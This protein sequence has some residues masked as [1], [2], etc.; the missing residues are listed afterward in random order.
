MCAIVCVFIFPGTR[1][2]VGWS[3]GWQWGGGFAERH[4]GW[5]LVA[6]WRPFARCLHLLGEK[7][8][9][10]PKLLDI[11]LRTSAASWDLGT[12]SKINDEERDAVL[13]F[14]NLKPARDCEI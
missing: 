5:K 3:C 11:R 9:V 12:I 13:G 2:A 6:G 14:R 1:P 10:G 4:W 8:C 7:G